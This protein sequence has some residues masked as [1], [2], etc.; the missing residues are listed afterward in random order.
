LSAGVDTLLTAFGMVV[1]MACITQFAPT[2]RRVLSLVGFGFTLLFA[3]LVSINRFAQL[4]V[5][6]QS[7]TLADTVG[8]ERFMPYGSQSVFFALEMLGWGAFLSIAAFSIAPLFTHGRLERWISIFFLMY[9]VLGTTAVIGYALN[10]P[11]IVLGYIAW[12]PVLGVAVA[13]LAFLFWRH[14]NHTA[15]PMG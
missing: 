2:E 9:G 4:T 10:S 5:I 8:L 6:R 15:S 12:G 13:L 7:L 11:L 1:L 3:A 14:A